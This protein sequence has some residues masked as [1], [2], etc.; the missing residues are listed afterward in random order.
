MFVD[1]RQGCSFFGSVRF[2]LK[3][4][5]K[6]NFFKKKLKPVQ[7]DR[8]RFDLIFLDKN[9]FKPVWLSFFGLAQFFWFGLVFSVQLCFGS[10]CF[11]FFLFGFSS[12][13]FFWFRAYK[14]KTEPNRSVFFKILVSFF[15]DSVFSI[16]FFQFSRFNQFFGFFY[17]FLLTNCWYR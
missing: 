12:V 14:T 15:H 7:T 9:R 11:R 3:K 10:V 2:L 16:I 6:S 1:E 17:S 4:I 8:F 5:T 13:R